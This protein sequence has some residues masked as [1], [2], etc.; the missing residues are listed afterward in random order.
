MNITIKDR[1]MD[2]DPCVKEI[3]M[4]SKIQGIFPNL[5]E[6]KFCHDE[7]GFN[8]QGLCFYWVKIGKLQGENSDKSTTVVFRDE[9]L[10]KYREFNNSKEI[11]EKIQVKL[12]K[13][14]ELAKVYLTEQ[15]F[16]S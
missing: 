2:L 10:E 5:K 14:K 9:F 16:F 4:D 3:G 1:K 7:K 8:E 15:E 12:Q 6:I 13:E 11:I